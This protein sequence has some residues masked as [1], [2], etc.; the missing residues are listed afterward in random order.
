MT[1][2]NRPR[3][4]LPARV[5]WTRRLLLLAVAFGLV[6]GVARLLGSGGGG[7]PQAQPVGATVTTS[8]RA[9][10]PT[11]GPGTPV[12][13]PVTAATG[14]NQTPTPTPLATP[15][16]TCS[17]SDV[18]VA[19][20][21]KGTAYAGR[22][23]VFTMT[24]TTA[25]SPA[26]TWEVSP[27][28]LVVKVTSGSDRIWSTQEC[29]GAVAKQSVVVRKDHPVEVSVAWNGQRSD[30]G[31]TRSTDWAE[32]GYYHVTTAAFGSEPA[33]AQFVLRS[34]VARTVTATPTPTKE[35]TATA[36]PN[37]SAQ[38]SAKASASPSH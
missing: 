28:A 17:D 13:G 11:T 33:D 22:P 35:A 1:A 20:S 3:G 4:P 29:S 19:P 21:V 27:S 2:V 8:A 12:N 18:V 7:D 6:F 34:P 38:A 10:A 32:P 30:S 31:C 26:C 15:S 23:V 25:T 24:L 5:Y 37:A 9:H 14:K 36:S 16:G